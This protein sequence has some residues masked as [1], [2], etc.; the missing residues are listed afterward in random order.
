MRRTHYAARLRRY[1]FRK[2]TAQHLNKNNVVNPLVEK[3]YSGWWQKKSEEEVRAKLREK[4]SPPPESG[5][6][7][8][9]SVQRVI[10]S[11]AINSVRLLTVR[12]N[13]QLIWSKARSPG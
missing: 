6:G 5:Y 3:H 4:N 2:E 8:R 11:E 1:F 10:S 12:E 9:R 13:R 7:S